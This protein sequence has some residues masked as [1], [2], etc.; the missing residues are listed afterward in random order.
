MES[1]TPTPLTKLKLW[2]HQQNAAQRHKFKQSVID[3]SGIDQRTFYRYLNN[4]APK[5]TKLLI[6]KFCG[7]SFDDLYKNI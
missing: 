7:I 6:C 5:L 1:E 3:G 4:E 2:Y